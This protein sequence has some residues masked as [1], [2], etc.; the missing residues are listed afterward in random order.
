MDAWIEGRKLGVKA[1][2]KEKAKA[3]ELK[4]KIEQIDRKRDQM[5]YELYE[6][7]PEEIE[8]VEKTQ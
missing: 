8:L 7:T 4:D 6:L 1:E 5:I 3:L 2:E